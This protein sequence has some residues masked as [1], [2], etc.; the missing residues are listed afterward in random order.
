MKRPDLTYLTQSSLT[1]IQTD[2]VLSVRDKDDC[3]VAYSLNC[4]ESVK[5]MKAV[6]KLNGLVQ[7]AETLFDMTLDKPTS[8]NHVMASNVLESLRIDE[9]NTS[10]CV[11]ISKGGE[12]FKHDPKDPNF[13]KKYADLTKEY[14]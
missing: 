7:L 5:Y 12:V 8:M 2:N 6:S 13:D 1:L 14:K 11:E 4:E 9:K 10:V 3:L